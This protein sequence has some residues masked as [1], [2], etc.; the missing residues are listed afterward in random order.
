MTF[1]KDPIIL[2][3]FVNTQLRDNYSNLDDLCKA[4]EINKD[5]LI[6]KLKKIG[7]KIILMDEVIPTVSSTEIR[8]DFNNSKRL[9]PEKIFA[10]LKN[11]GV[12]N[13]L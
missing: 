10:Y 12:Y 1:P 4:L 2:L 3:S 8:N 11:R 7:V 5:E 9:I 6:E 13:A